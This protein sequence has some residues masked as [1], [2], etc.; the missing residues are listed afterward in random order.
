MTPNVQRA[1]EDVKDSMMNETAGT[2][3][4]LLLVNDLR[5]N[6]ASD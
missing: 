2:V 1:V 3:D 6:E 4:L 5:S